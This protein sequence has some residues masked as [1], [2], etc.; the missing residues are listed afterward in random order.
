MRILKKYPYESVGIGIAGSVKNGI[1]YAG[2]LPFKNFPVAEEIKNRIGKKTLI[3]NDANCAARGEYLFG[4]KYKNIVLL[5]F[6]T[7]LGGGIIMD[8]K[9]CQGNGYIGE[10]G[11][12][13]VGTNDGLPIL[14]IYIF[15]IKKAYKNCEEHI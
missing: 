8:N 14:N 10:F 13:I 15:L 7:G 12:M 9:L 3:D 1:V 11:H 6:G 5:T 2:N 4:R